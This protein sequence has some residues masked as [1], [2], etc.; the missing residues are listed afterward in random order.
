M[1]R[2]IDL[3]SVALRNNIDYTEIWPAT[4]LRRESGTGFFLWIL[5]KFSEEP[6][7]KAKKFKFKAFETILR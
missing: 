6:F 2:R 5:R 7:Y 3:E 1:F 4:L